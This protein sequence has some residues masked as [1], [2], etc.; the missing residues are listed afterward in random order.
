MI[1]CERS[2]CD[3]DFSPGRRTSAGAGKPARTWSSKKW[4]NGPCPTSWSRPAIRRVSVTRPSDGTGSPVS[5]RVRRRLGIERAGPQAGLVHDAEAMGEPRVL[6]RR[7]HPA[8]AL[9][10]ADPPEPL[11][12]GGVEEVLL[13]DLLVRQP[14]GRRLVRPQSLGQ[15]HVAVDRV[16]DQVD[17]GER[18]A[19]HATVSGHP[20]A[21]LGRPGP[22]IAGGIACR[23]AD[24]VV[25][26]VVLDRPS[27][28]LVATVA[29][30]M[31]LTTS[32]S[33]SGSGRR[34]W[35]RPTSVSA[36]SRPSRARS[37][38]RRCRSGSR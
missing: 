4:A 12:P 31:V 10:L 6:G 23:D 26:A 7:E 13:G 35:R 25:V 21:H 20:D 29:E 19:S 27:I 8:G 9:E 37:T 5:M 28:R 32:P 17:R 11:E 34:S 22:E 36:G 15:L 30:A 38:S 33:R 2:S 1:R 18:V 14:G 16:A 24:P 3:S